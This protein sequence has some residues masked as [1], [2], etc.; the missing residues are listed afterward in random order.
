MAIV[1][2]LD[3]TG[4]LHGDAARTF[5]ADHGVLHESWDVSRADTELTTKPTLTPEEQEELVTSFATG[6]ARMAKDYGYV[7]HDVIVLN[8]KATPNLAELL[9]NFQR[10]HHHLEDEVR[11]IVAG[12]GLFTLT[13]QG[14]TFSVL[15]TPG[16]LIS[17]P[18]RTRHFFTLTESRNVKAIRLF[19]T[20]GG[21]N[22]IYDPEP[23]DG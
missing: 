19:Q 21:W 3:G 1:T 10:E 8:P 5:L 11:L 7:S 22:A 6:L 18:A 17:V 2:L 23:A 20:Q 13:R 4:P 9:I 15:V 14:Q 16:D 12:E